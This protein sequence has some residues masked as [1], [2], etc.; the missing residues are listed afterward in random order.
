MRNLVRS[1]LVGAVV[2]GIAAT[3][4]IGA[5]NAMPTDHYGCQAGDITVGLGTGDP[6]AGQQHAP[7]VFRARPGVR[8]MLLGYPQQVQFL[9]AAGRTMTT[10]AELNEADDTP[11][12]FLDDR[13]AAQAELSWTEIPAA[14]GDDPGQP[15]PAK[16]RFTVDTAR[17]PITIDWTGGPVFNHGHVL[18]DSIQPAG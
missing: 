18:V 5:A 6:G 3:V 17:D 16:V 8:C 11:M 1:S 4:T 12:V 14:P 10:R 13:H 2:A 9:D 7:L 15:A